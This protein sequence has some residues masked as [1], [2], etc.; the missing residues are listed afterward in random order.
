MRSA[1]LAHSEIAPKKAVFN[2]R[3]KVEDVINLVFTLLRM[4]FLK[5]FLKIMV[6]S[7]FKQLITLKYQINT[8]KAKKVHKANLQMLSKS[9]IF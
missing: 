5:N 7:I 4:S 2:Q 9:T 8:L 1:I 3:K 6:V